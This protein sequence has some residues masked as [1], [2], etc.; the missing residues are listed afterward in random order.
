M[1]T[2]TPPKD[3]ESASSLLASSARGATFLISLQIGSRALTFLVNQVLLRH[4]SPELLGISAQL[5]LYSTTVLFLARESLRVAS[6]R[7]AG[8]VETGGGKERKSNSG[9][10]ERKKVGKRLQDI[11]NVS[12][13][14]VL[15]GILMAGGFQSV[16]LRSATE[17]VL[18]LLYFRHA[19]WMYAIAAI[20]ELLSEP[21][22][23][24]AQNQMLYGIRASAE[25]SATF[26]RCI[27][28]CSTAVWA[29]RSGQDI[30]V[31]PFAVG[32]IAYA[33]VLVIMYY[34]GVWSQANRMNFSLMPR[35]I[36]N[37]YS[38]L[39]AEYN[40]D[41]T[42]SSPHHYLLS[43]FPRPIL[44]LVTSFYGQSVL[45]HLL[46]QGDAYLSALFT[47]TTSQGAYA[48][49]SNYGSLLARMVFQPI[50]ESSR[51]VFS[52]LLG[53]PTSSD[54]GTVPSHGSLEESS[55]AGSKDWDTQLKLARTYLITVLR[56][57]GLLS[58]FIVCI[59]PTLAPILLGIVAGRQWAAT[60]ATSVLSLYCYYIPLLAANG[61]L[62]AFVSSVATPKTLQ[63]QSILMMAFSVMFGIISYVLLGV[64]ELGAHGLVWANGFNMLL[65]ILY[66]GGFVQGYFIAQNAP[67]GAAA[68]PNAATIFTGLGA[69][70]GLRSMASGLDDSFWSLVQV[71]S[72]AAA[73]GIVM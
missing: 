58:T 57:Y 41:L 51:S 68:Y 65:R 39:I 23:L 26:A 21:C 50:E 37:E 25:A 19:L 44:S 6:L 3:T 2:L 42:F 36:N 73:F 4:L 56:L 66:S 53:S 12:Y 10:V 8:E 35:P 45:K 34:R 72:I 38:I 59:G 17:S 28:N 48:L 70:L 47:T 49:A 18:Q 55:Q 15:L 40:F 27:L 20:F 22:F 71:G 14:A 61:I 67:L 62:E 1:T 30:G 13:I 29:S 9:D 60:S 52:R 69:A 54:T 64:Y 63:I 32:Q 33:F 43:L 31:L 11:V 24:V 46:T 16:Y 5:E 7:Y